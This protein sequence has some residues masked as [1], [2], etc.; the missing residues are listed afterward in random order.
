MYS[1][2]KQFRLAGLLYLHRIS[3]DCVA[4]SSLKYFR[5]FE[6]L[7]GANFTNTV[8][9]TTMWDEVDEQVGNAHEQELM[10]DFWQRMIDRGASVKRFLHTRKSA[11][12]ILSPFFAEVQER[13]VLHLQKEIE[14]CRLLQNRPSAAEGLQVGLG[15][16]AARH[17]QILGNIQKQLR[18]TSDP[19]QLPVLMGGYRTASV[20]LQRATKTL[21]TTNISKENQVCGFTIPFRLS[22]SVSISCIPR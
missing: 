5:F 15:E 9:A 1:Y 10:R 3:D 17:E 18:E 19:D 21:R 22:R 14:H 7:C 6:K 8:L 13:S 2:R 20:L 12:E 16:L 4:G 11:F